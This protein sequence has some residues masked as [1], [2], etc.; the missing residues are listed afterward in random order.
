MG[1]YY[2]CPGSPL[3]IYPW[4]RTGQETGTVVSGWKFQC[5]ESLTFFFRDYLPVILFS[6][7]LIVSARV[8]LAGRC[9]ALIIVFGAI[10]PDH[11]AAAC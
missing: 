5:T 9:R 8:F 11:D 2:S 3:E 10:I 6:G 4:Y 1:I 7:F